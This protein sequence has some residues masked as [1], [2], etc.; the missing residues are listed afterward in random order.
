M[1]DFSLC[2]GEAMTT[3][4]PPF[5]MGKKEKMLESPHKVTKLIDASIKINSM[6]IQ[7]SESQYFTILSTLKFICKIP[8]NGC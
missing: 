7:L 3:L 2:D 4:H 5:L 6:S 1:Y 8:I